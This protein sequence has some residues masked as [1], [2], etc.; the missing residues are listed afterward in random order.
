MALVNSIDE[1]ENIFVRRIFDESSIVWG[2]SLGKWSN[3]C[4]YPFHSFKMS[5]HKFTCFKL[6]VQPFLSSFVSWISW[7]TPMSTCIYKVNMGHHVPHYQIYFWNY[8]A[9]VDK[10]N[11]VCMHFTFMSISCAFLVKQRFGQIYIFLR[12]RERQRGLSTGFIEI[13]SS[14]SCRVKS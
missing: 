2:S 9:V 3:R 4:A 11:I 12:F 10:N 5:I 6:V 1:L 13:R 8:P 14:A 7:W